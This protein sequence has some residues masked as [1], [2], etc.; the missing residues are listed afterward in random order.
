[1]KKAMETTRPMDKVC[2]IIA[3]EMSLKQAVHNNWSAD[4]IEGFED[5]GKGQR[6]PCVANYASVFMV[7]GLFWKWKK[8]FRCLDPGFSHCC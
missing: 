4:W 8:L 2:A 5:F 7:R 1:M 3:D 6:T